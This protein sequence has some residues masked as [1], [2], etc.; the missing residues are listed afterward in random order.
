MDN[1]L[2]LPMRKSRVVTA[3]GKDGIK[4]EIWNLLPLS[5]LSSQYAGCPRKETGPWERKGCN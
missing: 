4:M 2:S 5:S 3:F 1:G